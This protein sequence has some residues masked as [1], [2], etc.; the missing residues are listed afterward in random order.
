MPFIKRTAVVYHGQDTFCGKLVAYQLDRLS[1]ICKQGKNVLNCASNSRKER[2]FSSTQIN[3]KWYLGLISNKC[4]I[5][6][7]TIAMETFIIG[8]FIVIYIS[9]DWGRQSVTEKFYT[10][11][12][13]EH[14]WRNKTQ[15]SFLLPVYSTV[16]E[17]NLMMLQSQYSVNMHWL[18]SV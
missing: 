14:C 7:E 17:M 2:V 10:F 16:K 12:V 1:V 8:K 5:Y 15:M 3:V 4:Y 9:F 13:V 11:P 6:F 18:S